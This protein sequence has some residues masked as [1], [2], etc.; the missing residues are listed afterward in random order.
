MNYRQV[1]R[2]GKEGKITVLRLRNPTSPLYKQA[3]TM[4]IP[5]P[6]QCGLERNTER[7]TR[8]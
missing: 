2:A 7:H 3:T 6:T 4:P 5:T 8:L 1:R